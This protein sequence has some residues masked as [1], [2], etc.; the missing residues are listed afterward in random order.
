M[1]RWWALEFPSDAEH[2]L[3]SAAL[4]VVGMEALLFVGQNFGHIR[5]G[6]YV[7]LVFALIFGFGDVP[8][9]LARVDGIAWRAM[10]GPR[11]VKFLLAAIAAI[12][13]VE[14]LAAMAPPTGS[15]ALHYHFT[16]PLLTLRQ[17]FHPD[18]FLSYSFFT[19]QSHLLV[20]AGLAFGSERLALGL[21]F[22]G[23]V[24][25]A[26]AGACLANRWMDRKWSCVVAL[27]F[28][29]TPVVFWQI[30]IA[31]T[32]DLW[33]A[34]FATTSVLVVLH[35]R[36]MPSMAHAIAAGTLAGG[37]AGTKYTGCFVA[38]SIAV[39]Y[40]WEARSVTKSLLFMLASL[41]AGIWPYARNF[42][43]TGDPLFP[44]LLPR[45]S[46]ERVNAFTLASCLAD[47]GASEHHGLWQLE[48]FPFFAAIDHDHLGFWQFLGPLVLALAPLVIFAVRNTPTWRVALCVWG[49]C[50]I[51]VGA[52]TG[53][54]R[55]LLPVLPIALAAVVAGA[56]Q[57]K[58]RGWLAAHYVV[59]ASMCVFLLFG[60]GALL[61]YN[62]SALAAATGITA[63]ADYLR[64]H[65]PEYEETQFINR[66]LQG[67]EA[68]GPA[69]VFQRHVYYLRIPFLY[70]D[71]SASW[72]IDPRNFRTTQ[73][74]LRLF[75]EQKVR[76]VVR[77]PGY[78][79]QIAG[80]LVALEGQGKL[81][82]FARASVADFRGGR[83]AG[84]R[85]VYE[86]VILEVK[87]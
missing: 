36:E 57:L 49:V 84:D 47:T 50:A 81:V 75:Q 21:L 79:P 23:G 22:L 11:L 18:F 71:P 68:E 59:A 51:C 42:A 10:H 6:V 28:L 16:A 85:H 45:L 4:G 34:F 64:D 30:S 62:R 20:L 65:S 24:L 39:A 48:A 56:A 17:G 19:G 67:R 33:L 38:A 32:P 77:S 27:L 2:L 5:A 54:M 26:A 40:F 69:L 53:M 63:P 66:T 25:A 52:S 14:G 44:F 55:F 86:V 15:D 29:V 73:E 12:L 83:L 82:P 8:A 7:V 61:G 78:P 76:W 31:G 46:P 43:W 9:A 70:A 74:W 60:V 1:L 37:A 13:L 87:N 41:L 58:L 72:A 80:P 3:C 35:S